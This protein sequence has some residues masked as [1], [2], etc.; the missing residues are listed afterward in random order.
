MTGHG[1]SLVVGGGREEGIEDELVVSDSLTR[2]T[3]VL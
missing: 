2:W 3:V 1:D